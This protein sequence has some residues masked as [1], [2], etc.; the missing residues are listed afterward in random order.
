VQGHNGTIEVKSEVGSGTV[1]RVALPRAAY[2]SLPGRP[3]A[4]VRYS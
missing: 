2:N 3:E 1:F 4:G